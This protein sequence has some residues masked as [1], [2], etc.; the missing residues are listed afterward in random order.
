MKIIRALGIAWLF[1][2]LFA[3]CTPGL[4]IQ[5]T[6]SLDSLPNSVDIPLPAGKVRKMLLEGLQVAP[7]RDDPFYRKFGFHSGDYLYMNSDLYSADTPVYFDAEEKGGAAWGAE[8]FSD[9]RNADDLFVGSMGEDVVSSYYHTI[10]GPLAY[11]AKFALSLKPK[12]V[13]ITAL[14][15]RSF[16]ST[17]ASGKEFN[18]HVLG[19]IP[20]SVPVAPSRAEEYRLLVYAAHLTGVEIPTL[21]AEVKRLASSPR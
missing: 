4:P 5:T 2:L 10:N 8:V 6:K 14:S 3:S 21:E 11:T 1:T 9:P 17:V 20:S 16:D 12:D 19:M 18:F 13:S 15:V 7:E